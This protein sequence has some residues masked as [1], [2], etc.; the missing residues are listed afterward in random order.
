MSSKCKEKNFRVAHQNLFTF[1]TWRFH[2]YLGKYC[3]IDTVGILVLLIWG[4]GMVEFC[5]LV[6]EKDY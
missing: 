1:M 5:L 6:S 3:G 2:D 4:V